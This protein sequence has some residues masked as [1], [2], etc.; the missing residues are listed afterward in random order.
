VSPVDVVDS[1]ALTRQG[2]PE[3]AQA[4]ANLA[5]SIDFPRPAVTD[6]T[7]SVRPAT[8][9]GLSPDQTLVLLNGHRGHTSALV[10]INGSIGRGSAPF[11]LNTIPTAALDRVEILRE[12]AAAQY[13]SDAIAGVINLRLREA[14]HGGGASAT[15]GVYNTESR[16]PATVTAAR[17]TTARPTAPRCGK[18]SPC[19]TTAS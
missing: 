17:P 14:S 11:D 10:N 12:G 2:T 19:P 15:Y 13:G 8:L 1:K 16:R 6:G 7:D 3:L 5:P 18:A 9:R 4:L